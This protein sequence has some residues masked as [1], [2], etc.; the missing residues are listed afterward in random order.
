MQ[1]KGGKYS[2]RFITEK[3][4]AGDRAGLIRTLP[5]RD[6]GRQRRPV[7]ERERRRDDRIRRRE[8]KYAGERE[9]ENLPERDA[10]DDGEGPPL[11]EKPATSLTGEEIVRQRD[12]KER[13]RRGEMKFHF[14]LSFEPKQKENKKK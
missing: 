2:G 10:P 5:E 8:R 13:E 11:S 7:A 1:K 3:R 4:P 14:S 9:S 12:F 6:A